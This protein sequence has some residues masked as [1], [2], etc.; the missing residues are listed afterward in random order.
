MKAN[1]N[2]VVSRLQEQAAGSKAQLPKGCLGLAVMQLVDQRI[3]AHLFAL[4][5]KGG[6]FIQEVGEAIGGAGRLDGHA[7]STRKLSTDELAYLEFNWDYL[8][9]GPR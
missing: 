6:V 9:K 5:A 8:Y 1:L 3:D 4:C 2:K 7:V